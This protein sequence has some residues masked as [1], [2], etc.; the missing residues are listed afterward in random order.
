MAYRNFSLRRD[1][2]LILVGASCFYLL[3]LLL[4]HD[5][6]D[7][8][9]IIINTNVPQAPPPTT[10]TT[11]VTTTVT[12]A[13]SL[14]TG[15]LDV[16]LAHHLPET[17]ILAHAPGWTVYRNLYMMN[18]TLMIVTSN[19]SEIPEIRMMTS[20][21]L[22]ALNTPE[23]I[24]LREPSKQDMDIISPEEARRL[25]GGDINNGERH[26]IRTVEGTTVSSA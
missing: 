5:S 16:G 26:R 21:G 12:S 8:P 6:Q 9:T 15:S 22:T 1:A 20:T 4:A 25:W 2:I 10:I 11:T 19:P 3:S 7:A 24:A 13:P 17:S 14:P 18:G 23:N